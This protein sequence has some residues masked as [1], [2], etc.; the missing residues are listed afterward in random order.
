MMKLYTTRGLWAHLRRINSSIC[1]ANPAFSST[2]NMRRGGRPGARVPG[3]PLECGETAQRAR[4]S[5][6]GRAGGR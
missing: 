5:A 4:H 3:P 2:S 1:S 6:G